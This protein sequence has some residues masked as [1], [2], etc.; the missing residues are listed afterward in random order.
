MPT[1]PVH[2]PCAACGHLD[3]L[4]NLSSTGRRTGCSISDGPRATPCG[5]TAYEQP[6]GA[7][8]KPDPPRTE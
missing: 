1:P 2:P 5:C 3:V 4:H 7:R 6:D 8:R